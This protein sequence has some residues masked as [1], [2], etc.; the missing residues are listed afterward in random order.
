LIF[1]LGANTAI[2]FAT[3]ARIPL[4]F[5]AATGAEKGQLRSCADIPLAAPE[6]PQAITP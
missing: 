3:G 5:A 2:Y 4:P 6:A 1:L